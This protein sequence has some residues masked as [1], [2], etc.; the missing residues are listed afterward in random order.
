VDP[1]PDEV[2]VGAF[3]PPGEPL[4][5]GSAGRLAHSVDE[6][7][8]GERVGVRGASLDRQLPQPAESQDRFESVVA[9]DDGPGFGVVDRDADVERPVGP[10][11]FAIGSTPIVRTGGTPG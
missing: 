11:K 2:A 4:G 7:G 8:C 10:D 5:G 3:E 1:D 6:V 9:V